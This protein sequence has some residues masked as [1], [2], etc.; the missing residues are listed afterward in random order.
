MESIRIQDD[1]YNF[2]NQETLEKLVIPDDKP[3]TGGFAM[4]ADGVE[5][6]MMQEFA[7]MAESE[8]YPNVYL[9]RACQLYSIIM[10]AEKKERDGIAPALK[11]LAILNELKTVADFSRLYKKLYFCSIPTPINIGVDTDMKNTKQR[12][13]YLQGPG[14]I[15]PDATY[16]RPEMAVQKS[17][18][19][20]LWTQATQLVLA[21]TDLSAEDQAKYLTDTLAFDEILASLVKTNEE[22]SRYV[23]M[24]NPMAA[25]EV[26]DML[27]TVELDAVLTDLFGHVPETIVVTEPRYF[28]G[29]TTVLN[30]ENLEL[31][32]HWAYVTGLL[33][34]C[35]FLSE[36]LRE[37][38]YVLRTSGNLLRRKVLR[39]G[40]KEGYH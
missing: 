29:F 7:T 21:K 6:T 27:S 33:R 28:D 30:G 2:V 3:A 39:R 14:V 23:E 8:T 15:L 4:L 35:N 40:G 16:Y 17:Q 24:Y 18:L 12:L 9:E 5:K 20:A 22:W 19:I 34:S 32:K 36:E 31:Y 37:L 11:N 26:A 25:A 13:V 1:L 38:R 10:D